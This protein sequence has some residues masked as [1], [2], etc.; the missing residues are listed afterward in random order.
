[1]T[2]L[3]LLISK[4]KQR[5]T[6]Y[7]SKSYISCLKAFLDGWFLK[8][9]ISERENQ[10]MS[11]FQDWVERKYHSTTT[12]S[13]SDLILFYS[14]GESDA[15]KTFFTLFD[16]FIKQNKDNLT[17]SASSKREAEE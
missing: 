6:M 15:L 2:Q 11:D 4:I 16:E 5:P 17:P 14:D 12:H 7:I 10:L 8:P 9:P 1:M 13:W 3:E